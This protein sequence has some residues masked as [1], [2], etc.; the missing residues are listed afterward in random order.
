MGISKA[1]KGIQIS[2]LITEDSAKVTRLGKQEHR[3]KDQETHLD[4]GSGQT[5]GFVLNRAGF[6]I[7][8]PLHT[9]DQL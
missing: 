8:Y 6:I 5:P 9:E 2:L 4:I 1:Q 7:C 3:S